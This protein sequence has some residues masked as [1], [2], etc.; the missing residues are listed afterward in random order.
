MESFSYSLA[1][2][3]SDDGTTDTTQHYR[4]KKHQQLTIKDHNQKFATV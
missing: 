1:Y 2:N 4:C 3:K